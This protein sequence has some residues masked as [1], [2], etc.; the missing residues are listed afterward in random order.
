M[1]EV[2]G[3]LSYGPPKTGK[4]RAVALPAFVRSML[5]E[6][7]AEPSSGGNGPR[8]PVF[9]TTTGSLVRH[10]LFY[11]RHFKPAV[12]RALPTHKHGLRFHD[13]RHTC[14]ALL[15]SAGTHPKEVAERWAIRA[16]PSRWTATGHLFPGRGKRSPGRSTSSTRRRR[17]PATNV[18]ALD[19][20]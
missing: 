6:Y 11:K 1:K 19:A 4:K 9:T 15:I 7:L 16:S 5:N 12:R 10:N 8:D 2:S 3:D 17:A 20:A 14:A 13:L 18:I